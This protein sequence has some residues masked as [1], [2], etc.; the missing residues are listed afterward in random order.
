MAGSGENVAQQSAA[1]WRWFYGRS[2][3]GLGGEK[4]ACRKMASKWR[5]RQAIMAY[6]NMGSGDLWNL[7]F[8]FGACGDGDSR[9][10]GQRRTAIGKRLTKTLLVKAK[11]KTING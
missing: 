10:F 1:V 3:G 11:P 2:G 7:P 5:R 4:K 9:L 8:S 6:L